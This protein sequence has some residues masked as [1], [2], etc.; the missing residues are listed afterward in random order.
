MVGRDHLSVVLKVLVWLTHG[1][2]YHWDIVARTG[3]SIWGAQLNQD[4]YAVQS[5]T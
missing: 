5:R 3:P 4:M 1:F 2:L